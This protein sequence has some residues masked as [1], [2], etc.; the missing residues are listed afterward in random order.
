MKSTEKRLFYGGIL[1]HLLFLV[2]ALLLFRQRTIFVDISMHL[3]ELVRTEHPAIQ[4]YRFVALG[5]QWLPLLGIKLDWPL[6]TLM[7][8]YSLAFPL[9]YFAVYLLCGAL[10]QYRIALAYLLLQLLLLTDTFYWIQS[11]LPQGLAML[12]LLFAVV[13]RGF[14]R[15]L[16]GRILFVLVLAVLL[17][18]VAFAHPLL[19][20]AALFFAIFFWLRAGSR[21]QPTLLAVTMVCLLLSI[22]IKATLFKTPYDS[23]AMSGIKRFGTLFPDYFSLYANK[24]LLRNSLGIYLP[25]A[26]GLV[27]LVVR[28]LRRKEKLKLGFVAVFLLGYILLV[29]VCFSGQDTPNFY[30]EN[31]Y[32]VAGVFLALPL[33][34]DLLPALSGRRLPA[35]GLASLL[36][37]FALVRIWL[38]QAPYTNRL[39]WMNDF[40]KLHQ[41]EKLLT[42]T[43]PEAKDLLLMTWG[44]PYEFWLLSTTTT[45]R[46]AS[47]IINDDPASLSWITAETPNRFIVTWGDY[48]YGQLPPRYFRFTDSTSHYGF[49]PQVALPAARP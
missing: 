40:L 9:L 38:A 4:N 10:G 41:N 37:V 15:R 30:M 29:H 27:A 44:T 32:L 7:Q 3:F 6:E 8:A 28:Y 36:A 33:V 12:F 21:S 49:H 47:L 14:P 26:A 48:L 16:P 35:M 34:Y 2:L 31:M 19:L 22:G 5:T 45:G 20:F 43:P 42:G 13:E 39:A 23:G 24:R 11:E 25:F 17:P 18:T 1:V 46:T